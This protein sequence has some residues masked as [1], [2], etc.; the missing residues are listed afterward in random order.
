MIDDWDIEP[1]SLTLD[2]LN[3]TI[4]R[5][6]G[7]SGVAWKQEGSIEIYVEHNILDVENFLGDSV[8]NTGGSTK[9]D[10]RSTEDDVPDPDEESDEEWLEDVEYASEH[11]N[12]ELNEYMEN[13]KQFVRTAEKSKNCKRNNVRQLEPDSNSGSEY[14]VGMDYEDNDDLNWSLID[15]EDLDVDVEELR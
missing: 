9:N 3:R 14:S 7:I 5:H 15:E 10:P 1:E 11:E 8:G 6:C 4:D 12:D 13:V 2:M